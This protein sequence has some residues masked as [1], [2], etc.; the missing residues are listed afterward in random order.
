M[1][2]VQTSALTARGVFWNLAADLQGEAARELLRI[3]ALDQVAPKP[4]DLHAL[5]T[6][7]RTEVG[8]ICSR[9]LHALEAGFLPQLQGAERQLLGRLLCETVA[10]AIAGE[11]VEVVDVALAQRAAHAGQVH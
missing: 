6:L 2:A 9:A 11:I 10:A 7:E 4:A 8:E 5:P 1:A 3:A